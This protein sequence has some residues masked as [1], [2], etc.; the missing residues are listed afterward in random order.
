MTSTN[1]SAVRHGAFRPQD[2]TPPQPDAEAANVDQP[3]A[4]RWVWVL[5]VAVLVGGAVWFM[6]SGRQ[7]PTTVNAPAV[8]VVVELAAMDVV[9]VQPQVLSRHLP[10]SGTLSPL[11][12]ATLKSKVAGE[13]E[14][15]AFHEGQQVAR[16]EVIARIDT[17][18]LQAQFQ[19][20]QAAVERARAELDIAQL[21]RD[22]NRSLLEQRFI[23]QATFEQTESAHAA[24]VAALKLAQAEARVAQI[25]LED[26][27]VRAPFNGS[28]SQRLAQPGEKVSADAALVTLVDLSQMVLQ[29]T[30]PTADVPVVSV[31]QV[32]NF[33]VDGFGERR[34]TGEVQRINPVAE[35]GSRVIALYVAVDNPQG[36][37]KGGMFAQGELVVQAS[38]PVLAVARNA[39][40]DAAGQPYVYVFRDERIERREVT[41]GTAIAGQSL[42]E[43]RNGLQAGDQVVTAD[44]RGHQDGAP[45]RLNGSTAQGAV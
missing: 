33:K 22:K 28:I 13:V 4:R 2:V 17:R 1:L 40:H 23:S 44:M 5:A 12:R 31:G 27:V 38:E 41:L 9:Q 10:L 32:V 39:V 37:L 18:N 19:R 35:A 45:A 7:A 30:V 42:V 43:I 25:A 15:L 16:G 11:V 24:N 20:Q 29:A 6:A 8:P 34:F 21:N 14:M 3:P 36:E 26:A